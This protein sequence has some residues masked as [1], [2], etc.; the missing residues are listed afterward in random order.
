[1]FL[2]DERNAVINGRPM[3]LHYFVASFCPGM[4]GLD[5]ICSSQEYTHAQDEQGGFVDTW[6]IARRFSGV[7]PPGWWLIGAYN[8]L[9][10]KISYCQC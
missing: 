7:T 6:Q 3:G 9:P 10:V 1:M 2:L 8:S 4:G 5:H